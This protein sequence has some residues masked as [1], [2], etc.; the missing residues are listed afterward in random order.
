MAKTFL[1][2][3][4]EAEHSNKGSNKAWVNVDDEKS[5]VGK[6]V[7]HDSSKLRNPIRIFQRRA[8]R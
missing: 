1:G 2:R 7:K 6:Q 8:D 5:V 3:V 4:Y